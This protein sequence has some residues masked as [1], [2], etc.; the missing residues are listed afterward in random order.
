MEPVAR[1]TRR[2]GGTPQIEC[3]TCRMPVLLTFVERVGVERVL[4]CPYCE[5]REEWRIDV[6][7]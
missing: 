5:Q 4:T 1:E 2:R 6:R 7:R 3:R